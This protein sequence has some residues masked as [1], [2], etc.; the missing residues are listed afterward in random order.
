[1]L[2][3]GVIFSPQSAELKKYS[4]SL[5]IGDVRNLRIL[6]VEAPSFIL[7]HPGCPENG[8]CGLLNP[9]GHWMPQNQ[10]VV[11]AEEILHSL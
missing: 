10:G 11:E 3:S 8:S 7:E 1:M 6:I 2:I 5:K 4:I 9:G